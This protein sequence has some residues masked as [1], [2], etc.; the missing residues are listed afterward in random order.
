VP[1]SVTVPG[2][3]DVTATAGSAEGDVTGFV[4]L[5][6]GTTVRRI[7]FWFH[8]AD[9]K[10]ATSRMERCAPPAR[11]PDDGQGKPSVVSTYR[12]PASPQ[13]V[14]P[15]GGPEQCSRSRSARPVANF[16]VAVLSGT[17]A[18]RVL[19]TQGNEDHLTAMPACR[20]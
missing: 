2:R 7:P 5:T 14:P 10:L 16:G 6:L 1:G 12:Y 3:L 15:A 4:V 13:G 8:T 20:S 19:S 9:P 18:H 11:M 17:K